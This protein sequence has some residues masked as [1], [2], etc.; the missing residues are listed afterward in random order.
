MAARRMGSTDLA[1]I[2]TFAAL[3]AVLAVVPAIP[4][5]SAGV[6]ITLQTAGVLL[7]G[8][9]LGPRRGPLAVLLY[10][11]VGLAGAP[12]FAGGTA[13][14]AVL[15]KPSIGYLIAF[16]FAAALSGW[17]TQIAV[18]ANRRPRGSR[19]WWAKA[20]T[21]AIFVAAFGSSLAFIHPFGIIGMMIRLGLTPG[22]AI[23]ADA[24]FLPGDVL[25]CIA[26]AIAASAA[27]RAFPWLVQT[28]TLP[29]AVAPDT[30][31]GDLGDST[32]VDDADPVLFASRQ[33]R[34]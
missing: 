18:R 11:A 3:I 1:L 19:P 33:P 29:D 20:L 28:K 12:I 6:P 8:T 16:P 4:V 22:A 32:T 21:P 30:G 34:A 5:G 24:V 26:V 23:A 15:A 17:L 25:K 2:A 13:G 7:A 10:I 14:V 27:H 31:A 9:V